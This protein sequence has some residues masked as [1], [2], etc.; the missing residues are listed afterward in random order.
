MT[1]Q[2]TP[3]VIPVLP[4]ESEISRMDPDSLKNSA[5]RWKDIL[6]YYLTGA[7]NKY[8]DGL[9]R[10]AK[11]EAGPK[12]DDQCRKFQE[13]LREIKKWTSREKILELQRDVTQHIAAPRFELGDI[14]KIIILHETQILAKAGKSTRAG[15]KLKVTIPSPE[16]FI[17]KAVLF[18][19]P[20]LFHCPDLFDV[21][22]QKTGMERVE[23]IKTI[24]YII[25]EGIQDALTEAIPFAEVL[26]VYVG[27][28]D[29]P[30][31][32]PQTTTIQQATTVKEEKKDDK[33]TEKKEEK[34]V[35]EKKEEKKKPE[36]RKADWRKNAGFSQ[37]SKPKKMNFVSD[38]EDDSGSGS[39]DQEEE[40][41]DE[42]EDN[43][44]QEEQDEEDD[45]QEDEQEEEQQPR[46]RKRGRQEEVQ[47][48]FR[49]SQPYKEIT[50][51]PKNRGR[52]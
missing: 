3:P 5:Q 43:N 25:Q 35:V 17:H 12:K 20:H 36:V 18:T 26:N 47:I 39:S 49:G 45:Q 46:G 37:K 27:G 14:L 41:E 24:R 22:N 51:R 7:I 1:T 33:S 34:N 9:Y 21:E 48:K 31:P 52:R 13:S 38:T 44:D 28:D 23:A 32:T 10:Q 40:E 15:R 50:K 6:K 4:T 2:N 29:D 16:S 42:E 19:A 30:V 11:A 8:V